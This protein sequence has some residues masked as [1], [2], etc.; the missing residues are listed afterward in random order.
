MIFLV[1]LGL[2]DEFQLLYFIAAF[3]IQFFGI[4]RSH[5]HSMLGI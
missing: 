5:R 3:R 4:Y 2:Q 1:F